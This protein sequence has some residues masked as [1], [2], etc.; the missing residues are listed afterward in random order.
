QE[1]AKRGLWAEARAAYERVL[2][3]DPGYLAAY[4]HG[5]V[6]LRD[7]GEVAEARAWLARGVE[8]ARA[9]GDDKTLAEM[10]E[11]LASLEG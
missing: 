8:A 1:R 7:A 5:A 11:L 10:Q 2:H 9:K 4:Y 6:A 3:L